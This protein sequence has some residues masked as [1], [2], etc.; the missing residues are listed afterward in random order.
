VYSV[1]WTWQASSNDALALRYTTQQQP[2]ATSSLLNRALADSFTDNNVALAYTHQ[3]SDIG[4]LRF[5]A[6]Y[7]AAQ[8][9]LG[10]AS[11]TNRDGQG[12]LVEVEA[13]WTVNF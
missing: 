11:Y 1:D 9:F 10:N 8:N 2:E 4:S 6:S 13:V 3:F 5:G 12:D 7:A